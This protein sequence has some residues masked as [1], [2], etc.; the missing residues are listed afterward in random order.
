[1]LCSDLSS[2]VPERS[3]C[4][5]DVR[6]PAL[7]GSLCPA[8][9][10]MLVML[11]DSVLLSNFFVLSTRNVRETTMLRGKTRSQQKL[12]LL[13]QSSINAKKSFVLR[14]QQMC[15]SWNLVPC[16]GRRLNRTLNRDWV[17]VRVCS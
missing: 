17:V 12:L 9:A 11:V 5:S 14:S 16:V 8:I 13:P 3:F 2:A 10:E 6:N 4:S 1:M 7:R 15:W